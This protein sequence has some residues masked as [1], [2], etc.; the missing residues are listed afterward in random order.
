MSVIAG[1]IGLN[2]PVSEFDLRQ[3]ELSRKISRHSSDNI[4]IAQAPSAIMAKLDIGAFGSPA[5]LKDDHGVT[6][7]AG[8][9]LLSGTHRT[10]IPRLEDAKAIHHALLAGDES[11]L[12]DARGSYACAHYSRSANRL[13][14]ITDKMGIRPIYYWESAELLV[15]SSTLR[16]LESLSFVTKEPDLRGIAEHLAFGFSLGTRT[17]YKGISLLRPGELLRVSSLGVQSH[18]YWRWQDIASSGED[19]ATLSDRAFRK[20]ISAV[21]VRQGEDE[22]AT[23]FL[24]GGL[25][26]RC[27]VAALRASGVQ[28][29]TYNFAR[30]NSEDRIFGAE[31][32]RAAGTVHEERQVDD[33]IEVRWSS[34]IADACKRSPNII[35]RRLERPHLIWSGDGGSVGLGHV[36]IRPEIER[37]CL[38]QDLEGAAR[39]Y[40]RAERA[41]VP[42]RLLT[43]RAAAIM[44]DAPLR[45]VIEELERLRTADLL[46]TFYLMLMHND[47]HRHLFRHFEDID[48]HRI[49]L[50]LPFFDAEFLAVI[51]SVPIGERLYHRFYNQ[52]LSCFPSYVAGTYWQA[53][54]G[55]APC[56]IA[57]PGSLDYQWDPRVSAS[58]RRAARRRSIRS[59]L[60]TLLSSQF[61]ADIMRRSTLSIATLVQLTALREMD[62]IIYAARAIQAFRDASQGAER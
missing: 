26:S 20:F 42:R 31:L 39:A 54:P 30:P 61:A 34:L 56:P 22:F 19:V 15:F 62:H 57:A 9:P 45:G 55:H 51:L 21:H 27:V 28:V 14:L 13:I 12:R 2:G 59:G 50:Q 7:I 43:P 46:Q 33:E 10:T 11:L 49:E 25:D 29:N 6:M 52:W 32:A 24:S 3:S 36:Y 1:I 37:L 40:V 41:Y 53:Y 4:E 18:E 44:L 38:Q 23:S 58:K 16:L 48:L 8:E 47:Q 60:R 17:P 35:R 5:V